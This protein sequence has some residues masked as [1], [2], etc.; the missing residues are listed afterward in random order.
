M[1]DRAVQEASRWMWRSENGVKLGGWSCIRIWGKSDEGL[2]V[3][4]SSLGGRHFF[5]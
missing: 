1:Q 2:G 4:V 5:L 3:V